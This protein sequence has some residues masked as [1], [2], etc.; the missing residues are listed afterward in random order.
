MPV[1][2]LTILKE[3]RST[4]AE[5]FVKSFDRARSEIQQ[6]SRAGAKNLSVLIAGFSDEFT[7]RLKGV[8]PLDPKAP[9]SVQ[10]IPQLTENLDTTLAELERRNNIEISGKLSNAFELGTGVTANAFKSAGVTS[11]AFPTVS[12]ELLTIIAERT[13]DSV[14]LLTTNLRDRILTE[15]N[16]S[17]VGLQSSAQT[18][19][20]VQ[21]FL[22]SSEIVAGRRR[23]IGFGFQAETIV[24]TES[25]RAYSVAQQ[26]GSESISEQV[27]GLK[28]RWLT[29]LRERR[30]HIDVENRY[31]PKGEIGPIEIRKRFIVRDFSRTGS[32]QFATFGRG[33]NQRVAKVDSFQRSGI[34]IT[35]RM[36]FPRD[37]NASAGNV[38]N[39][40]CTILDIVPDIEEEIN[41]ASGS[42]PQS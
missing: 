17:A 13:L 23:R 40:T 20:K 30:G 7:E 5:R 21:D 31:A 36:L 16:K 34:V 29:S 27:P 35:D 10:I 3:Q 8:S 18:I 38:I 1:A 19:N 33:R 28:K 42:T 6:L 14:R 9:F 4:R 12:P 24:R 15:L 37:P 22:K 39:C 25:L 26:A 2:D 11:V 41:N 32:S